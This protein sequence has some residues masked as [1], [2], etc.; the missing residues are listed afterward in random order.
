MNYSKCSEIFLRETF[1]FMVFE[2]LNSAL[3]KNY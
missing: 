1:D 3:L 2:A